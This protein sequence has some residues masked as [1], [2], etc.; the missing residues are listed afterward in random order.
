MQCTLPLALPQTETDMRLRWQCTAAPAAA[1]HSAE[2]AI[3]DDVYHNARAWQQRGRHL[4][5]CSVA[6]V[7]CGA[8]TLKQLLPSVNSDSPWPAW[9]HG[10]ASCKVLCLGDLATAAAAAG[11]VTPACAACEGA[12]AYETGTGC[13]RCCC[14]FCCWCWMGFG[15]EREGRLLPSSRLLCM[16]MGEACCL[17]ALGLLLRWLLCRPGAATWLPKRDVIADCF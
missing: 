10:T 2:Q 17:V 4:R 12:S 8:H 11:C 3:S 7:A 15:I 6:D 14:C 5:T 9:R 16:G 13:S 1:Y